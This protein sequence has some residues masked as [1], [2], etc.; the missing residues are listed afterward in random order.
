MILDIPYQNIDFPMVVQYEKPSVGKYF[1]VDYGRTTGEYVIDLAI[2][3]GWTGQKDF[4]GSYFYKKNWKDAE[5]YI[6]QQVLACEFTTGIFQGFWGIYPLGHSD[7]GYA[8]SFYRVEQTVNF[9]Y[10]NRQ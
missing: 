1:P 6:N 4:A 5:M 2:E 7:C 8:G 3:W 10:Q 9:L